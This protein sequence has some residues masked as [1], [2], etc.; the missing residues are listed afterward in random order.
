V[1]ALCASL[2]FAGVAF[3][4]ASA[5]PKGLWLAKDGAHLL[6][7]SCGKKALCGTLASTN[8]PLDPDTGQPFTD[9]L[10]PDPAKRGRPLV[11]VQI[12]IAMTANGPGK[13]SGY[14]YN[15]DDGHTYDGNLIEVD[16]KT[17]RVEGCAAPGVCGGQNMT[18]IK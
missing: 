11:G 12:L 7:G 1:G 6:I 10:N 16:A 18:R 2:L 3:G 15:T 9:K 14:L 5:D 4:S 17:I 13:W 8:P